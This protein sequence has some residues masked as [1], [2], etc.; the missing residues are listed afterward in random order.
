MA[1]PY[2]LIRLDET[3]STQDDARL[4]YS[5]RPV[6]V[7]ADHQHR[8]RGRSGSEWVTAARAVA[9]SVAWEPAWPVA[10]RGLVPLVAGWSVWEAVDR[11]LRLKWP[12]DVLLEGAKVGGILV[13]V[14][15]G[16]VVAGLGLNLWWPGAPDGAGALAISD[17]GRSEADRV[18]EAWA[19]VLLEITGRPAG[20]WSVDGYRE[21]CDTLGRRVQWD[22]DGEGRAVDVAPDGG[23]VVETA[24]G[25]QVLRSG[26]VRHVRSG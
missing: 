9:V 21:I 24:K 2:S 15:G 4:A 5:G 6:V 18:A 12:N 17:P 22:P 20:G 25:R 16:L 3:G 19:R 8:G 23:L 14:S 26:E 10:D 7:V 1:T 13:E 11:R